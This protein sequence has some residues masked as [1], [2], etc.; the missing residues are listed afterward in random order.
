[1][2]LKTVLKNRI[3][4]FTGEGKGKT[5]AALGMS[6]R[7]V[8]HGMK[9]CV[10]HFVKSRKNVGEVLAI[11]EISNIDQHI[12]GLG[13]LP[14]PNSPEFQNHVNA[15]RAGFELAKEMLASKNYDLVVLDEICWAVYRNLIPESE[16][17]SLPEL[18][19]ENS[20]LV[21]TGRFASERLIEIADT[22]T[23]MKKIKHA[24]E[25]GVA[26]QEGVEK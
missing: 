22:V 3:L 13:F 25:L 21:L 15:A 12:T 2:N 10:I 9:V 26:A 5:T 14:D 23:E 11:S 8:G 20:T 7:A 19:K 17:L 24:Y 16:V 4:I 18:M 1:M 6:L